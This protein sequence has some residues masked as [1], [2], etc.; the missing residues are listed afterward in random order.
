LRQN[1]TDDREH[2]DEDGDEL[3]K[4]EVSDLGRGL[5]VDGG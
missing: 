3:D 5:L 4:L 1:S 2:V